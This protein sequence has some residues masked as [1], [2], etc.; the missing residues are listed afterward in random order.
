[1]DGRTAGY[2][3]YYLKLFEPYLIIFISYKFFY[4]FV[5]GCFHESGNNLLRVF[6]N[7]F[8]I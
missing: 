8:F 3:L 6:G 1:M 4:L 7:S 2:F 5:F